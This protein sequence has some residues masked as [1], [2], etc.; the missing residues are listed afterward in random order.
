MV[1]VKG[2][3]WQCVAVSPFC[4]ATPR[5]T[6]TGGLGDTKASPWVFAV[7][8][9]CWEHEAPFPGCLALVLPSLPWPPA[10]LPVSSQPA[11]PESLCRLCASTCEYWT[12]WSLEFYFYILSSV[13]VTAHLWKPEGS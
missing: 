8:A 1:C 6:V 2:A 9:P 4:K 11:H 3:P 13:C 10:A 5:C 7:P 12:A